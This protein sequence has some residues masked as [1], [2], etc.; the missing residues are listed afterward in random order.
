M[1]MMMKNHERDK[2]GLREESKG[3]EEEVQEGHSRPLQEAV[4]AKFRVPAL[5]G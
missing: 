4:A 1:I 3:A 5:F 2:I